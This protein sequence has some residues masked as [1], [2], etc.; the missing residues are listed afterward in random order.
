M[1]PF[2]LKPTHEQKKMRLICTTLS[3]A[4][5]TMFVGIDLVRV[6]QKH[7]DVIF[8]SK[9]EENAFKKTI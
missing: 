2:R 5:R 3:D 4:S 8:D 7:V 9:N 6:A 1:A